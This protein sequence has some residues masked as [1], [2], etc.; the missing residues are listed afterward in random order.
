[1]QKNCSS[2]NYPTCEVYRWPHKE[3]KKIKNIGI[4]VPRKISSCD[5]HGRESLADIGMETR[6]V[7]IHMEFD[8][9]ASWVK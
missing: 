8:G 5:N 7:L 9:E 3:W 4:L 2:G 1:M 6:N